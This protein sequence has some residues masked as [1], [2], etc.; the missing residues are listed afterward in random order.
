MSNVFTG[1]RFAGSAEFSTYARALQA[2]ISTA[3]D[4]TGFVLKGLALAASWGK[5]VSTR[6]A[7][8]GISQDVEDAMITDEDADMVTEEGDSLVHD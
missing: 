7:T 1:G 4:E 6:G 3:G 8:G 5:D 2:E